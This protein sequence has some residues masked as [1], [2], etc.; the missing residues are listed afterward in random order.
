MDFVN[1]EAYKKESLVKL[2][3]IDD[4]KNNCIDF[5]RQKKNHQAFT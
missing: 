2:N 5:V 4:K 1:F 3:Y